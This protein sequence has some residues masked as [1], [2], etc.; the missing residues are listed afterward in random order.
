MAELKKWCLA[1]GI[2]LLIL[3][4]LMASAMLIDKNPIDCFIGSVII[5]CVIWVRQNIVEQ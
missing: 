5:G 4:T 1:V 2:T 3:G